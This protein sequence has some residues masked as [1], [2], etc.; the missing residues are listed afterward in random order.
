[1][2]NSIT[3]IKRAAAHFGRR[4]LLVRVFDLER[5]CDLFLNAEIIDYE[6][7]NLG[8]LG[9]RSAI[10]EGEYLL[11]R[12]ADVEVGHILQRHGLAV[13]QVLSVVVEDLALTCDLNV[14]YT[15]CGALEVALTS[16]REAYLHGLAGPCLLGQM[17]GRDAEVVGLLYLYAVV[18]SS[19]EEWAQ[20]HGGEDRML[21]FFHAGLVDD[22]TYAECY[23]RVE[24]SRG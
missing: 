19:K 12:V 18:A 8:L 9:G 23:E 22:D 4:S 6:E 11:A 7:S 13:Y 10:V 20:E 1:M 2:I 3:N 24:L 14:S 17:P 21:Y 15:V 5:Q 16:E